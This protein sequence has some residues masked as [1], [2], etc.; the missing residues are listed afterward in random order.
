[1]DELAQKLS[2][3]RALIRDQTNPL[4][5]A[6]AVFGENMGEALRVYLVWAN[7]PVVLEEI[8]K[9]RIEHGDRAFLPSLE[10]AAAM[11]LREAKKAIE[12]KDRRGF[13]AI[14]KQ[15]NEVMGYIQKPGI[16]VNNNPNLGNSVMEVPTY[17]SSDDWAK[18]AAQHQQGLT[19]ANV[20]TS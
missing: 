18:A 6:M 1:M 10:D 8:T 3:A 12:D 7:D 20:A 17:A 16:T 9:L 15:F 14:M 2:F 11:L 13:V 5:A 4:G 19:S